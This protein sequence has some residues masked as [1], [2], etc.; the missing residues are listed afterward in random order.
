[1]ALPVLLTEADN[2][3]RVSC[4]K[5]KYDSSVVIT[6]NLVV[7]KSFNTKLALNTGAK[8]LLGDNCLVSYG[9]PSLL[10]RYSRTIFYLVRDPYL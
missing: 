4:V 9:W 8:G 10:K 6:V 1:M 5:H 3:N 7:S 2:L